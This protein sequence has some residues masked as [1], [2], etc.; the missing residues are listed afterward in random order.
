[1]TMTATLGTIFSPQLRRAPREQGVAQPAFQKPDPYAQLM[2]CWSDYMRVDDRDLGSRGMKLASDAVDERD[3]HAQQ[4]AADLK[5]GEV[6]NA[7]V[8]SLCI[9]HRWAIYK[10]QG[11]ASA[12]RFQNARYEDV[13]TDARDELEKKLRN[14]VAT[15]LQF[16]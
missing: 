14:N 11:I 9:Q 16:S 13:L 7:M 10:S 5:L 15:R 8:D 4:R 3:V 2:A 1:M 12:W 6:V